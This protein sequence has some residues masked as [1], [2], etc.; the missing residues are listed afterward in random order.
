MGVSV[1]LEYLSRY[2][3]DGKVSRVALLNGPIRLIN[4]PDWRFG[5]ER[6]ECMGYIDGLARDPVN[7]R[8]SFAAANLFKPTEAEIDFMFNL[9]MQ[10]PL[11]VAIKAVTHQLQLDHVPAL[12]ALKVPC[13]AMQSDHDFYP[14]ELGQ[15]IA[16]TAPRGAL[17]V[18]D[19]SGHTVQLQSAAAFNRALTEFIEE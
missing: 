12:K 9:S 15:Y 10:T 8:R 7:G 11:D 3:A 6:D 17:C 13:L 19:D 5:I 4:T 16:D 18:F 14:V 2:Q 1:T